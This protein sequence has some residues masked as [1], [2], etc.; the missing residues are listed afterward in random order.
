MS[1]I[2]YEISYVNWLKNMLPIWEERYF[3]SNN[4]FFAWRAIDECTD[5]NVAIPNWA[6]NYLKNSSAR[7]MTVSGNRKVP[8]AL[9]LNPGQRKTS[10]KNQ[11]ENF[12]FWECVY[13]AVEAEL[14]KMKKR[15]LILACDFVAADNELNYKM[16]ERAYK[17]FEKF[18][19]GRSYSFQPNDFEI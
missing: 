14:Q 8:E 1:K 3:Y 2:E 15:K 16:V 18:L 4:P 6:V 9:S 13:V 19:A 17:E 7:M 12:Y 10:Y 5:C 11:Y